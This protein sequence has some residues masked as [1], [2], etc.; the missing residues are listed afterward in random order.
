MNG[1]K[2]S[3][4]KLSHRLYSS[5][6]Y[7]KQLKPYYSSTHIRTRLREPDLD[8]MRRSHYHC[9]HFNHLLFNAIHHTYHSYHTHI[10]HSITG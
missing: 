2:W 9:R 7:G 4:M 5:A 6:W 8:S 1:I 10:R 3:G